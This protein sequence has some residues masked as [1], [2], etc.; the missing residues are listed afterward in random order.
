MLL[1]DDRNK[2][3]SINAKRPSDIKFER[4]YCPDGLENPILQTALVVNLLQ[5]MDIIFRSIH[6]KS[7][8]KI[9]RCIN[10]DHPIIEINFSPSV[11]DVENFIEYYKSFVKDKNSEVLYGTIES[12]SQKLF[13]Y[14]KAGIIAISSAYS[15]LYPES[16][17]FHLYLL[18]KIDKNVRLLCSISLFRNEA[19][20]VKSI[21]GRMN[22]LL[23]FRDIETFKQAGYILYDFGGIDLEAKSQEAKNIADFKMQLSNKVL[24]YYYSENQAM[25]PKWGGGGLH[26]LSSGRL[27]SNQKARL[28]LQ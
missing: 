12:L 10:G 2:V 14:Q 28:I 21:I 1:L 25:K 26:Y 23:H 22:R 27:L 19:S 13:L 11:L 7:Q 15:E 8:Y 17:V 16:K 20:L 24:K 3:V 6:K 5:D 4:I 9:R 18:N